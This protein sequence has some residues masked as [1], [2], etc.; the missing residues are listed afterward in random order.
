M[1]PED[2]VGRANA[3][4]RT[5]EEKTAVESMAGDD[6]VM[7]PKN[8][9]AANNSSIFKMSA[10]TEMTTVERTAPDGYMQSTA[11][12]GCMETAGLP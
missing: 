12:K 1:G 2:T 9:T 7:V 5:T 3:G 10:V 6:D 11:A 8:M 4:N